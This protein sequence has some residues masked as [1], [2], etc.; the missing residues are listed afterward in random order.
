M[1][2]SRA[3]LLWILA[4]TVVAALCVYGIVALSRRL[5]WPATLSSNDD[6]LLRN[7]SGRTML[8][9]R[10][11]DGADGSGDEVAHIDRI[12]PSATALVADAGLGTLS[13]EF[14]DD[15]GDWVA[16]A[17]I[18]R[19]EDDIR[20]ETPAEIVV[21]ADRAGKARLARRF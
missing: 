2:R 17:M 12:D 18:W 10:V 5:N 1:P 16:P 8:R 6:L 9:V 20:G 7:E 21:T 19:D 15:R 13:L 4:A 11:L 3:L 14:S